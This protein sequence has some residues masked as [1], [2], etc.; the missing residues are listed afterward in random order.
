MPKPAL[1]DY[2]AQR[3]GFIK[4]SALGDI[5]H[6]LPVLTALR[7]RY[8]QASITWIVN[9]GYEPLLGGHP[10]LDATLAFDRTAS[11][12]GWLA[13]LIYY[14]RFLQ[15]IRRQRFDLIID[16]QGLFRSGL[17]ALASGAKRRVGLSSARE[18]AGWF[19]TDT[20]SVADFNAIHAVD[21]YWLIAEALGVGDGPKRFRIP[22]GTS[23]RNWASECLRD[24]PRPW[25][26]MAAG[27]RWV[28]KRWL[29]AHFAELARRAQ[30]R[31]DGAIV[32]VGSG[33]EAELSAAIACELSGVWRD[34][35]GRTT[36]PQLA[37]VIEQAD[38]M[39]AND[40]GPLHL[41]A[42][43][44]RPLVAPYT[45][46]RILL[47]GP[48]GAEAGAVETDIWCKGS[49]L[50]RCARLDCMKDLTAERLWPL[51]D[52]ALQ[53]WERNRRSA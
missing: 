38:L 49:Y 16:A 46:T 15:E 39:I 27:S 21:R 42:A 23:E 45:C 20:V 30:E 1:C 12:R 8:P 24:V 36:L 31:Y 50:K 17:M 3:I 19:Y 53:A 41:A 7:E 18:G 22:I 48:Y 4:P 5:V 40:T 9:R 43:L 11:R 35:T 6:S 47:N 52:E 10:D 33:D 28:T 32:F 34:L 25:I 37:A 51:V 44:G 29:P 2:P 14:W 13:A 26:V